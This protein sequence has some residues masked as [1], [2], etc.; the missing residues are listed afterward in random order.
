MADDEFR[1]P[2]ALRKLGQALQPLLLRSQRELARQ[3][4]PTRQMVDPPAS[5]SRHCGRLSGVI[6]QLTRSVENMNLDVAANPQ[7][8][9]ADVR[10]AVEGLTR[11]VDELIDACRDAR[12]LY[13]GGAAAETPALMAGA[14]LHLL[15][16]VTQWLER[17]VRTTADPAAEI[18]RLRLSS[19]PYEIELTLKL[20]PAPQ[21]AAL[22][23]WAQQQAP[24]PAKP[25]LLAQLG[26]VVLVWGL[27]NALF[28]ND[29][30]CD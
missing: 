13:A 24:Q 11:C 3:A 14:Y 23:Q 20:S 8:D 25:G 26:V 22:Q 5:L 7:A 2:P 15:V 21:L 9:D 4:V 29:C 6:E 1:L 10:R 18:A 12:G 16:E 27:G 30:G 19:P 28:G 17:L